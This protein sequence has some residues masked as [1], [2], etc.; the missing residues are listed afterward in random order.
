MTERAKPRTGFSV[1]TTS[2]TNTMST[3][4]RARTSNAC[5]LSPPPSKTAPP[6]HPP[7]LG[8]VG[9]PLRRPTSQARR[10]RVAPASWQPNCCCCFR[11]GQQACRALGC[12][13]NE[14]KKG[15]RVT[16]G[17][18]RCVWFFRCRVDTSLHPNVKTLLRLRRTEPRVQ[19]LLPH[20]ARQHCPLFPKRRRSVPTKNEHPPAFSW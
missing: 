19:S 20:C 11:G 8:S 4:T 12:G 10:Q 3:R 2:N 6:L 14:Q 5:P 1:G 18:V 16:R 7:L 9:R 13:V 17:R 15:A